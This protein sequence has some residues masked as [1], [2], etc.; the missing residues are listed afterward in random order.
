MLGTSN[1]GLGKKETASGSTP[2]AVSGSN[3]A[4]DWLGASLASGLLRVEDKPSV[5]R[6]QVPQ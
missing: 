1:D 4:L 6:R 5:S 3:V 2:K